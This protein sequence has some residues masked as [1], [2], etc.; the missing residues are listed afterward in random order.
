M[1]EQVPTPQ[2]R[3]EGFVGSEPGDVVDEVTAGRWDLLRTWFPVIVIL[4]VLV[5]FVVMT[6]LFVVPRIAELASWII[7]AFFLSLALE[8]AVN[9]FA[10]RGWRRGVATGLVM[11]IFAAIGVFMV[12]LIVPS[13]IRGL[14]EL[15]NQLPELLANANRFTDRVGVD[16]TSTQ[17]QEAVEGLQDALRSI[18]GNVFQ[19]AIGIGVAIVEGLFAIATIGMF[20]FYFVAEGPR[21]R[22][23]VCSFLPPQ[24]QRRILNDWEIAIEKTGG[25]FY[26]RLLLASISGMATFIVLT[27][28][29]QPFAAPLAV[30]VGLVS[31]FIPT[32]GTYIAMVVPIVLALL[33]DPPDAIVLLIFFTAYQQLEN[34]VLSPKISAKTMTL[35]PAVAFAAV[36]LGGALFGAMGAFLALPVAAT[37]QAIV[38]QELIRH[39][40]VDSALTS[41]TKAVGGVIPRVSGWWDKI[42]R[43]GDA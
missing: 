28:L 6:T 20:L 37:M 32:V 29:G 13:V 18:A 19:G 25:Y 34:L 21:F 24:T 43:R 8:P 35:H 9:W 10:R 14:V 16:L 2:D 5:T 33:T 12:V 7:V 22:R 36:I 26:S 17:T 30:F 23:T 41:D 4:A 38:S 1:A 40:V 15:A 3:P 11:L 42:R 39:R 31:Q 27:L